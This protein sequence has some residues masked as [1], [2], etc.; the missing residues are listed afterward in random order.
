MGDNFPFHHFFS[1]KN[2]NLSNIQ[3]INVQP[4]SES[5][6]AE[7]RNINDLPSVPQADQDI[8][9]DEI[10]DLNSNI[11]EYLSNIIPSQKFNAY[12]NK[13]FYLK[14][15]DTISEKLVFSASTN[16]LKK[17]IEGQYL[18]KIKESVV[19]TLG[20]NHQVEIVSSPIHFNTQ[21]DDSEEN[22]SQTSKSVKNARFSLDLSQNNNDLKQ[23]VESKYINHIYDNHETAIDPKKTFETFVIGP[24]N[25]MAY[26][27]CYA[28]AKNPGKTYPT[29]YLHSKSGLGKTHLLH[30]VSNYIKTTFPE[31][32]VYLTTAQK[33]L[34]EMVEA[35][36][37]QKIED[38]RKKY[39]DQL[40]VLII[41]D[42][43][44][45]K[46]RQGTQNAFFHI[47]NDLYSK[48]KQLI[49]TSDKTPKEIDGIEE[50][51]RTRLSWGLVIDIQQPDLETRIAIL[52]KK[53]NE[54]DF[55]LSEEVIELIASSIKD[56]IRELEGSLIKL[57]AYAS[58][59]KQDIDIEIA[60]RELKLDQIQTYQELTLDRIAK[61]VSKMNKIPVPDL[62]SKARTKE[63]T[64]SR[65][66]AM[67]LSYKLLKTNLIEIGNFY[68]NRD[69]TTVLHAVNKVKKE[70][71]TNPNLTQLLLEIENN[72]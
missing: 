22:F 5:N 28:V 65:H 4:Q 16:Y 39:T 40:D 69:H 26:A 41:D 72:L 59:F 45:L 32:R 33:F 37:E 1:N 11:L 18:D 53:A 52:K 48:G 42:I 67:Y 71:Q 46:N 56:N 47:F 31:L 7:E 12:F 6:L 19:N 38:F 68:G 17:I 44:E 70:I 64:Q 2:N 20:R 58:L 9:E 25:N 54:L 50:R 23:Q 55:Y 66:I 14:S 36:K 57:A 63:V 24:S 30:G 29:V 51:I 34:Q 35:V 10:K 21:L 15:F 60:R 13:T 61:V 3:P 43:H 27:S 49:F 62:K 8:S